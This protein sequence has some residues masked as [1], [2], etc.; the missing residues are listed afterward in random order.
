MA[1]DTGNHWIIPSIPLY[2]LISKTFII[3]IWSKA[4][5]ID[6]KRGL[7]KAF[8]DHPVQMCTTRAQ[9]GERSSKTYVSLQEFENKFTISF[10]L[11]K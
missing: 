11:Q 7:Y 10:Y 3:R 1:P 2:A 6:G 4:I 9:A 8:E 5:I